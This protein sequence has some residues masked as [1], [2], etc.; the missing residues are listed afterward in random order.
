MRARTIAARASASLFFLLATLLFLLPLGQGC[1]ATCSTDGDCS[2][3]D[4]CL[5]S[6]GSGCSAAG[7]CALRE[8]CIA[9]QEP[10]T[11]CSCTYAVTLNL[12]CGPN[13]GMAEPTTQGPCPASTG[14]AGGSS[15]AVASLTGDAGSDARG[16]SDAVAGLT[17]DAGSDAGGSSDAGGQ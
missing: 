4:V 5:F 13:G 7:H 12:F 1:N 17:G 14:D 3:D 10:I 15:D 2:G 9:Q 16:S 6:P 8:P 11:V